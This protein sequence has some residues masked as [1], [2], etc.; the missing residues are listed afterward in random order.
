[1]QNESSLV[2]VVTGASQGIGYAIASYLASLNY[3]LLLISR[4]LD[5][6]KL[7]AEKIQKENPGLKS[8][9]SIAALDVSDLVEVQKSIDHFVASAGHVDLLCNNAGYVKRGTSELA[10]DEFLKMIN[11]NLIGPFNCT[12]TF[13]KYMKARKSGRIINVSSRS[14]KV[15]KKMLGGYSASKFGLMGLN[16]SY[17]KE[18][19]H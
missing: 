13:A 8:A 18:L 3:Q 14:G 1:M 2:A 11:A 17:Y 12:Q 7:A 4:N 9:P 15:A 6:L 5:N 10:H 16:Q 19:S